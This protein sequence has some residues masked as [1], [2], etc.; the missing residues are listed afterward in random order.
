M[1]D[2]AT[3]GPNSSETRSQP[4]CA[5]SLRDAGGPLQIATTRRENFSCFDAAPLLVARVARQ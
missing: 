4:R 2:V 3:R 5:G 1:L